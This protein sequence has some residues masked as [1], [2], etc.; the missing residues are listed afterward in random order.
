MADPLPLLEAVGCLTAQVQRPELRHV[1][2][3]CGREWGCL[4]DARVGS[5]LGL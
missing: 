5:F 2:S 4:A 1:L 3:M